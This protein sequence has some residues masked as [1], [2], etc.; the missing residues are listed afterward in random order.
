MGQATP[1]GG[2]DLANFTE[3]A[4]AEKVDWVRTAAGER[5]DRLELNL[6]I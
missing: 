2:I 4:L 1:G 6:L 3:A 5:F